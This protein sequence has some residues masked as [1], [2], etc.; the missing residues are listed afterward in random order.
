MSKVSVWISSSAR[1]ISLAFCPAWGETSSPSA[2]PGSAGA[3]FWDSSAEKERLSPP[4]ALLEASASPPPLAPPPH[5]V[6]ER[7][8]RAAS[9]M[10]TARFISLRSFLPVQIWESSFQPFRRKRKRSVAVKFHF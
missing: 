2:A 6:R 3:L 1:R 9:H 7:A 10:V 5:A 8:S 4:P